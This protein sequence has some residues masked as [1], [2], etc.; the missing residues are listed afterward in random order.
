MVVY[1][2]PVLDFNSV[3]VYDGY[4]QIYTGGSEVR[5]TITL[6][7]LN[8]PSAAL[9]ATDAKIGILGWEGDARYT[10]DFFKINNLLFTNALNPIDNPW[11]GT[12]TIKQNPLKLSSR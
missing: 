8:V 2:N 5:S 10:G 9:S 1:E 12:K 11:N 4:Q 7:G 6:T 3:R